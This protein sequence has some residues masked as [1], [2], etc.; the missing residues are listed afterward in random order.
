MV[1]SSVFTWPWGPSL[2]CCLKMTPARLCRN[3]VL[4]MRVFIHH[5]SMGLFFLYVVIRIDL[6]NRSELIQNLIVPLKSKNGGCLTSGKSCASFALVRETMTF[7]FFW[8]LIFFNFQE[9]F[10]CFNRQMPG[11]CGFC[12]SVLWT[13]PRLSVISPSKLLSSLDCLYSPVLR[14]ATSCPLSPLWNIPVH[15]MRSSASV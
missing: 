4:C 13:L 12:F 11:P 15:W 10:S 1:C 7:T 6:K 9:A 14:S 3:V 5:H 8:L 2:R